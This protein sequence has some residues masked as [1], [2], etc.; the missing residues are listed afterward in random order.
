MK[1]LI[2][3]ISFPSCLASIPF[4]F[5]VRLAPLDWHVHSR[6]L[7]AP[8]SLDEIRRLERALVL[9]TQPPLGSAAGI[10]ILIGMILGAAVGAPIL[11]FG[12]PFLLGA[13]GFG[14]AGIAAGSVAAAW[15]ASIGAVAAGSPFAVLQA[16]GATG[17][18]G[19]SAAL[20][21]TG[22]VAGGAIGGVCGAALEKKHNTS[23]DPV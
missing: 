5:E 18:V 8:P 3:L 2:P 17:L 12:A 6:A 1:P 7:Y 10:G 20:A 22:A 16:A 4:P 14:F 19:A 23:R 9:S 11:I 13:V 21:T 15:Q